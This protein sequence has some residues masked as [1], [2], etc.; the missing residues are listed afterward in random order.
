MYTIEELNISIIS[1][2]VCLINHVSVETLTTGRMITAGT[3]SPLTRVPTQ[4][5]HSNRTRNGSQ[6]H[7]G[8]ILRF[9]FR[10]TRRTEH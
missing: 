4:S 8:T 3:S 7:C 6:Y 10:N 1:T 9:L 2:F 5:S